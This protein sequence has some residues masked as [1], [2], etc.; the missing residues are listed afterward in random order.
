MA[1]PRVVASTSRITTAAFSQTGVVQQN[2]EL[3]AS[4][5]H[6]RLMG[7]VVGSL[8]Q[9][10]HGAVCLALI[11]ICVV[12]NDPFFGFCRIA[13]GTGAPEG[14]KTISWEQAYGPLLRQLGVRGDAER[15]QEQTPL[16][17]AK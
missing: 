5:E 17:Q 3:M 11:A 9:P 10:L 7:F 16:V 14:K 1:L 12:F 6:G 8:A 15:A 2:M 13:M 4:N